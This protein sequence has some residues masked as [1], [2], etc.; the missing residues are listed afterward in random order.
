M[1]VLRMEPDRILKSQLAQSTAA[2]AFGARNSMLTA[3][4]EWRASALS[5]TDAIRFGGRT[6]TCALVCSD[7]NRKGDSSEREADSLRSDG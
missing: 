4:L 6:Q 5:N 7:C 2:L 1:L 3:E